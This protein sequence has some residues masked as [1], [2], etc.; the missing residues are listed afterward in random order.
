MI[1]EEEERSAYDVLK[2]IDTLLLE[3]KCHI[4][5]SSDSEVRIDVIREQL[6]KLIDLY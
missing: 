2:Q 5:I 6:E 4:E 1:Y 3:L